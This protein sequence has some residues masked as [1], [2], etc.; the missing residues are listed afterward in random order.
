MTRIKTVTKSTLALDLGSTCGWAM[1]NSQGVTSG[2]ISFKKKGKFHDSGYSDL[3]VFLTEKFM[4]D[5]AIEI[6]VEKPHAG[7]FIN[8]LRILF[9]L[10][11]IVHFFAN[12]YQV[13][14]TEY[15]PKAIKKFATGNGN[16]DKK[17]MVLAV[18][19]GYPKVTDNN[20]ADALALLHLHL[21]MK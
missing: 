1:H 8:P 15:S 21:G 18:Q 14:L 11:A 6:A 2:T 19:E 13:T 16:A 17:R 12:R 10:L 5:E 20:E 4:L 7:R 3:Y 9:G